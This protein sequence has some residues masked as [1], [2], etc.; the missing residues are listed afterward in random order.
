MQEYGH[1]IPME[2]AR[3]RIVTLALEGGIARWMVTLHNVNALELRNFNRFMTA[4]I[5]QFED[6]LTDRIG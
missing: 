6:P 3:V 2:G 5:W 4:L 1:K